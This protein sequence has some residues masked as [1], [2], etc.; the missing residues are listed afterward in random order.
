MSN[1]GLLQFVDLA[2]VVGTLVGSLAIG[3]AM[4]RMNKDTDGFFMAGRKMPGWAVGLAVL[5]NLVLFSLGMGLDALKNW[6][7]ARTS[8]ADEHCL[9]VRRQERGRTHCPAGREES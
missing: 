3:A 8:T 5:A 4:V 2:M 9:I 7:R 6:K 1:G